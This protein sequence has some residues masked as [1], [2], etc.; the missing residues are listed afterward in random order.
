MGSGT[1]VRSISGVRL[2][3]RQGITQVLQPV[4]S[5]V[6]Q[7]FGKEPVDVVN[8]SRIL[9][10]GL[11]QRSA[12]PGATSRHVFHLGGEASSPQGLY[13]AVKEAGVQRGSGWANVLAQR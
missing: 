1:F 2:T 9:G 3:L 12:T 13:L 4:Q 6:E 5:G 11:P 7:R 10:N 8:A